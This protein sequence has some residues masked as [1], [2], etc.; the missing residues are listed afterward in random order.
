MGTGLT[1]DVAA[2]PTV[3]TPK[4]KSPEKKIE[5]ALIYCSTTQKGRKCLF[6]NPKPKLKTKSAESAF[7]QI[8]LKV[9]FFVEI[10]K[11]GPKVPFLPTH[12][13]LGDQNGLNM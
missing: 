8:D 1:I 6:Q 12:P 11:K 5:S 4:N 7:S 13:H 2:A 10:P 9:L 3:T